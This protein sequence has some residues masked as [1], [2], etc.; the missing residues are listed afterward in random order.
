[1][2]ITQDQGS[3]TET[4]EK[5]ICPNCETR[6]TGDT[7][8]VCGS[9]RPVTKAE[10]DQQKER[11]AKKRI[12]LMIGAV[13]LVMAAAAV[14]GI[15]VLLPLSHYRQACALQESG[16]YEQAWQAFTELGD[17][18]D[19][20]GKAED[21]LCAW[22]DDVNRSGQ[23]Q[24]ALGIL[25]RMPQS[26]GSDERKA[27]MC[28][29]WAREYMGTEQYPTAL[30]ILEKAPDSPEVLSTRQSV[31]YQYAQKLLEKEENYREAYLRFAQ[32][33][34]YMSAP[35]YVDK[36][37]ERWCRSCIEEGSLEQAKRF[38][39]TVTL[40]AGQG[41]K[42]Y[43]ILQGMEMD[44]HYHTNG[45][46]WICYEQELQVRKLLLGM[47]P[48]S[49]ADISQ[50]EC[51]FS[52]LDPEYPGEFAREHRDVLDALWEMPMVQQIIQNDWCVTEWLLGTWRV[53]N[54]WTYLQ[55]TPVDDGAVNAKFS[56]PYV[57]KPAGT[58]YFN[59]KDLTFVW[60]DENDVT[61]A[62]VFRFKLLAPDKMEV[63]C[64]RDG[65]TYTMIRE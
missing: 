9:P 44:N 65:K 36:T 15:V 4:E 31:Q 48:T 29:Q 37:V 64:F 21:V 58:K 54:A 55:F 53:E 32:L 28:I 41:E 39:E 24:K 18:Q 61:L 6:N 22:A 5:W 20:A 57:A 7:C 45:V 40:T 60:T 11:P 30:A 17:Y 10:E 1:M 26:E 16:Q 63:Y 13:V 35:S 14:Y 50:M 12:G 23:F 19:S 51:L 59:I 49:Y 43:R 46:E 52:K 2:E 25:D 42:V 3:Y 38:R 33:G 27:R 62:E 34:D 56:L 47:V 8:I